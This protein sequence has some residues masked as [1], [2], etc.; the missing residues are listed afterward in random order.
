MQRVAMQHFDPD[1]RQTSCTVS[2]QF[3]IKKKIRK[4]KTGKQ[5]VKS[6]LSQ[7]QQISLTNVTERPALDRNAHF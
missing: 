3:C 6:S 7:V 1:T 2:G 4:K 5:Y